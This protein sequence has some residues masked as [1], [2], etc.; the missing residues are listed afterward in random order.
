MNFSG[1]CVAI[2]GAAGGIGGVLARYFAEKEARLALIDRKDHVRDM[3]DELASDGVSASAAVADIADADAVAD[4]FE[5]LGAE[6]GPAGI[7][8]NNAGFSYQPTLAKSTADGWADHISGN[9]NGAY[10]CA[11]AVLPN[12][13]ES[14][15]GSILTISSVNALAAFGDPAYSAAKAGLMAM[16]RAIAQEYGSRGIRAN[17]VLPGTVRTPI[18]DTRRRKAPEVLA[19]LERWYPL[20]RIVEPHEVAE[21]VGFLVSDLASAVTGAM[22]PVDCGL[23]SGNIV[24]TRELTLEDI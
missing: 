19:K 8:I 17:A 23:S 7:L 11:Q 2:T 20:G 5:A 3:A 13:L 12:M 16:T 4:A 10:Q 24:M 21:V 6:L 15:K 18:W 14:G 1:Q 22:I 9:L